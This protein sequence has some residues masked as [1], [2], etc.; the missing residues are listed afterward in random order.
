MTLN[1]LIEILYTLLFI[2]LQHIEVKEKLV[3][4]IIEKQAVG[5][6]N[7]KCDRQNLI[8]VFVT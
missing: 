4:T 8:N 1:D 2:S 3:Q 5:L 7:D 6:V